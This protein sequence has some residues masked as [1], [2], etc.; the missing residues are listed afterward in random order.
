MFSKSGRYS[1][2]CGYNHLLLSS[3][4][5][6]LKRQFHLYFYEYAVSA[7]YTERV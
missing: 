7:C 4:M 6:T 5:L 3:C 1:Q 2:I